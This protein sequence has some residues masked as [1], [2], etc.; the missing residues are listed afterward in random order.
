MFNF[1]DVN[2]VGYLTHKDFSQIER[3]SDKALDPLET[4][5]VEHQMKNNM[6]KQSEVNQSTLNNEKLELLAQQ[7]AQGGDVKGTGS[8]YNS[9]FQSSP[10]LG[11]ADRKA[12]KKKMPIVYT[13]E[14]HAFGVTALP[15]DCM[16]GIMEQQYAE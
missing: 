15:S 9:V 16:N 1:L 6:R 10:S 14:E 8:P 13:S 5:A 4:R 2:K 11:I 3:M 12:L 7:K